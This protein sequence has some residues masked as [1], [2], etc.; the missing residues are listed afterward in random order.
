MCGR[1]PCWRGL[2]LGLSHQEEVLSHPALPPSPPHPPAPRVGT[3]GLPGRPPAEQAQ[4]VHPVH[5]APDPPAADL[6]AASS[7]SSLALIPLSGTGRPGPPCEP[8]GRGPDT[9]REAEQTQVCFFSNVFYGFRRGRE[10]PAIHSLFQ[11]LPAPNSP[12]G[13][14][15]ALLCVRGEGFPAPHTAGSACDSG[16]AQHAVGEAS[17]TPVTSLASWAPVSATRPEVGAHTAA[18][19]RAR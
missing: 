2:G 12:S 1:Q 14:P 5:P 11:V 3:E 8:G 17:E 18:A 13:D 16:S 19:P 6:S 7:P 10:R 15:R 9:G 4:R